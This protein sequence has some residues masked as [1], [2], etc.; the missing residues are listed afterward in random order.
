MGRQLLFFAAYVNHQHHRRNK[1]EQHETKAFKKKLYTHTDTHGENNFFWIMMR[2]V[3]PKP[4]TLSLT[5]S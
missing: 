4:R 5:T 3:K 2:W 1:T